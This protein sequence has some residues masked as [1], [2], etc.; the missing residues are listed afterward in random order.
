MDEKLAKKI[1]EIEAKGYKVKRN[2]TLVKKTF[3]V[4]EALLAE[5]METAKA[6][7]LK[8]KE[9]MERSMLLF[10]QEAKKG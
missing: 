3:E 1:R 7:N 4:P 10:I 2:V 5:F 9:A 6:K 8:V